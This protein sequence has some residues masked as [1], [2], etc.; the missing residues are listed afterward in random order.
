[1]SSDVVALAGVCPVVL[2]DGVA[3]LRPDEQ[4]FEA[5]L[6]GWRNQ[7]WPATWRRRW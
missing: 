4:A 1:M 7:G 6:Q 5:M 3:P 2:L